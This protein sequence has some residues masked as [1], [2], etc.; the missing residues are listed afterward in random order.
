MIVTSKA[1][2]EAGEKQCVHL[3]CSLM[4]NWHLGRG[5]SS[6]LLLHYPSIA[7]STLRAWTA[8]IL[9]I[10]RLEELLCRLSSG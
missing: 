8:L 10:P 9:E 6:P 3:P 4:Q 5:G 7:V 2:R 1:D